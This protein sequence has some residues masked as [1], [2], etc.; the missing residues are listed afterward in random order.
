MGMKGVSS[1]FNSQPTVMVGGG[2]IGPCSSL[3]TQMC[4]PGRQCIY[5]VPAS[6]SSLSRASRAS[7]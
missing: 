5:Y 2:N 7:M 6:G 4:A 3:N 1:L